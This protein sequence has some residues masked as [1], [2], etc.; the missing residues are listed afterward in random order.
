MRELTAEEIDWI[1]EGASVLGTGGGGSPY[2]AALALRR[3]MRRGRS[4]RVLD[5]D[6]LS[7]DSIGPVLCGMGAP[8]VGLERLLTAGRYGALARAAEALVGRAMDF[9]VISEIGGG[10]ALVP[11]L[12]AAESGLPV[13]DADA[14]GR[15]LPELS[16]NTFA[17]AGLRLSPLLLD[18]GKSTLAALSGL[19]DAA[20]AER[21]AR[22]LTWAMGGSAGLV[23]GV[24]SGSEVRRHAIPR[25]LGVA[26]AI[27]R[28]MALG[29][30]QKLPPA[31]ALTRAVPGAVHL[32]HGKVVDVART[33]A[34][35]FA[36]GTLRL[37][38]TD[39]DRGRSA[40]VE[41]QNEYLIA[42]VDDGLS[43]KTVLTAPDL[44]V[45]IERESGLALS[46]ERL[47]YGLR[48]A[49]LGLPAPAELKTEAA[50]RSVGPRAFGY[51]EPFRPLAGDLAR[52][53][54]ID[55][56]PSNRTSAALGRRIG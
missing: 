31:E 33:T 34:L 11:L 47:R 42:R 37:E 24:R 36:R 20:T 22:A 23:S 48:L 28:A 15:A 32:F 35:G 44:L 1:A 51:D 13:V 8:T 43:V 29:R 50:L 56:D 4:V 39:G 9:I 21:Y 12:A 6:E 41:F 49:M 18:D 45:L 26:R 38:G 27:G 40:R 25:M 3:A 17:I 46:T 53:V 54:T 19:P 2:Q 7:D 14:N 30:Q 5:P 52:D 10:N 55:E 16:M